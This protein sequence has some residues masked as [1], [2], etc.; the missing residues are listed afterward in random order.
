MVNGQKALDNSCLSKHKGA[1]EDKFRALYFDVDW[2]IQLGYAEEIGLG[3]RQYDLV[4][5]G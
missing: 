3:R 5:V 1:G 2:T 4:D